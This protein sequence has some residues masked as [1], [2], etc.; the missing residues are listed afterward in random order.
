MNVHPHLAARKRVLTTY[1]SDLQ[2]VPTLDALDRQR[3]RWVT[4]HTVL[5]G[6]IAVLIA[7]LAFAELPQ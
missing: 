3:V 6:A 4:H 2:R 5:S 1:P 7:R